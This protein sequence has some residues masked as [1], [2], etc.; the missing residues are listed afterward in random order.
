MV[1]RGSAGGVRVRER[2]RMREG[3][4][5]RVRV[6]GRCFWQAT[7]RASVWRM[8]ARVK[9]Q[10]QTGGALGRVERR[11]PVAGGGGR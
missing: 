4:R 10:E 7:G 9:T 1:V 6:P 8:Q 5:V 3:V 2:K 11:A